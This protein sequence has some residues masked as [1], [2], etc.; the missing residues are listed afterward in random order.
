M[1]RSQV[2]FDLQNMPSME[3]LLGDDKARSFA[4]GSII[5]GRVV[6]KRDNGVL[7]DIGYKAEG[8]VSRE[9]FSDWNSILVG[10]TIDVYLDLVEDEDHMPLMSVRKAELQKSWN[11]IV[12]NH[13]EGGVIAGIIK[14]RV[15]GGLIVDVGVDA[16]L[17]GSQVDIGPVRNLEDYLGKKEDFKI[18]KI[19]VERRNIV[20]SRRELLEQARAKQR[21]AL[22]AELKPQEIRRGVVKN[23]TDFGAFVDLN[24]MDGLLHIT[25]MSW[26]RI[27][28]PS[29]VVKVGEE[30]EVM[31]LEVD[32]ARERVSL[33]LKQKEGNPWDTV[34]VKY[35]AGGR[36]KGRVVNVMPY[37][38][39]VEL[40][41]GIEGLI[42]VSEMSW[43]RKITRAND[44]LKVGDE[45]EAL[46]LDVQKDARKISLGLRQTMVNPWE[47]IAEK[48][49]K[50]TKINGKVRNMTSYGAFVQIQDD[51]DGMIHV[52]DMS[53]TRKVNHPSEVLQ[54]GQDV[55]A[56]ILDIDASQQR[57][58][59]GMKQLTDDPWTTIRNRYRI[60]ELVEGKVTKLA[61]FGA[62][63]ELEQG[64]DGL[65]HISQLKEERVNRVKDVVQVGDSVKA[66]VVKID[67]DER[68]IG[69]SLKAAQDEAGPQ[70][71]QSATADSEA[72]RPGEA[73]VDVGDVFDS[74]LSERA[75]R[76]AKPDADESGDAPASPVTASEP[77]GGD[78][79]K[80]NEDVSAAEAT[81]TQP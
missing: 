23:V 73:L 19:D 42:H 39:F 79:P 16:F 12:Q 29:E 75:L 50:G 78:G 63:V 31:V 41:E 58:S 22:L 45:V 80:A 43:T 48:F 49:P 5:Q 20:L 44:V 8:V 14:H 72:L 28:H 25:D 17:P 26:G 51:I 55:E 34:E 2:V 66:R 76:D 9:E 46:I 7:L 74:A 71:I 4:E 35:P 65:I 11:R 24:G 60:G 18:L 77:A 53:W 15:K 54:K 13:S 6:E 56:V 67:T 30:I 32:R 37:G 10:Q 57:I 59:L 68:R 3:A 21:A 40:E 62:F 1:A 52:S 70:E 36:V 33:G 38:A 64:I 27:S 47:V 81:P 69:L 61:S